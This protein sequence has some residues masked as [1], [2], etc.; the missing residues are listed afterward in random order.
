[1]DPAVSRRELLGEMFGVSQAA[2]FGALDGLAD[3]VGP[4]TLL[5]VAVPT[6]AAATTVGALAGSGLPVLAEKPLAA[7][8]TAARALPP[9]D[10]HVVHNY[11]YRQD[12]REALRLIAEGAAG[13]PRFLR[14]ERL[15]AG[16]FPGRG[17]QPRW[18][19]PRWPQ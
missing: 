16:H 14:L 19:D 4:G 10:V 9:G 8:A 7:S 3:R 18:R 1:M 2:R 17:E 11:L 13:L 12:V 5:V 15:D 6:P